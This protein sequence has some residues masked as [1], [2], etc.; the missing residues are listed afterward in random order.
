MTWIIIL[1]TNS[2]VQVTWGFDGFE[3]TIM[4]LGE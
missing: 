3:K 4:A 1:E 2:L